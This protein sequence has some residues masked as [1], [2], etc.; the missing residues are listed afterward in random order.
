MSND[1]VSHSG[2]AEDAIYH[3]VK[4][5]P[6]I[7]DIEQKALDNAHLMNDTVRNF[8]WQGIT[9]VVKDHK[10][11]EPKTILENVEGSIEAGEIC[12]LMGPSG[13]GKTTLLNVLARRDVSSG[14]KIDGSAVVNGNNPS[15]GA[16]RRL[17]SYVEQDD[18]L[19]GSLTVRETMHFAARLAHKNTLTKTER[20]R[21]IDGLIESFG[22]R[23]QANSIIGTPIRKGISGGQKR[24]V[25]VASQL[26]TAP[27]ILFLDEPTSGLDSAASFEVISFVKEVAKRNNLIVIASIHQPSTSTFQLFDKLLLLSG[28]KSHYFGSVQG[29]ESQFESMGYPIPLHTNPAEFLLE[30]MNIDFASHQ[31][32][33]SGRL[34]EI[35]QSWVK[36]PKAIELS[37]HVDA[38][39]TREEPL[40]DTKPSKRNFPIILMTLVHR[41]FI[42]SYRDVVAYGIR[43]AMYTGL[44]I[45]MGT[46]W[47]RLKQDQSAIQSFTNAIFFGGAFMSFMAVAYIPSYLEDHAT[48]VKDRA[49]GLYGPA[50]FMLANFIIGLP[51]LFLIDV[52][53]SVIAYW[54]GNFQPTAQAFF[55]W[56]MWLFLDLVAAESLVVLVSSIFPNFVISL[57]LTAFANGLWMSV[58]GFMVSPKLLNVF[59]RYVFHYIDYQAYVFQGM[60]VNEFAARVYSCGSSCQCMFQTHMVD[61]CS[62]SGL[63]VLEQYG[64]KVGR[65]G[66]WVGILLAIVLGLRFLGWSALW[67]RK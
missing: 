65:T 4:Q 44:A 34:Q 39:M 35:Q 20:M 37:A 48:Y 24:R 33:A 31:E 2:T 10:T 28:G 46:V 26:I 11:K 30:L 29:V 9:V 64:Y 25:S 42:K 13:C 22:L 60:M 50:V 57:A 32:A 52:I 41:S 18:A 3:S 59:W 51:Y 14:A 17:T 16:F 49:N 61:Q 21:R 45:M 27:K 62:F 47:L 53:F 12:A 56:I 15:L 40:S 55:M 1:S 6:F 36:S 54:L 67:V 5:D 66:E 43:V 23:Q 38:A 63:A 7:I 19:I 8:V 58:N